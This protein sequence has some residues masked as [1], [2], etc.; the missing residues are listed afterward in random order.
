MK[1][2]LICLAFFMSLISAVKADVIQHREEIIEKIAQSS[3]KVK[4]DRKLLAELREKMR[5]SEELQGKYR[6]RIKNWSAVSIGLAAT[7]AL[8]S[9][10]KLLR[11]PKMAIIISGMIIGV[12]VIEIYRGATMLSFEKQEFEKLQAN[13][14]RVQGHLDLMTSTYQMLKMK[15]EVSKEELEQVE[16]EIENPDNLLL[17]EE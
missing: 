2:V 3:Y 17:I 5:N 7:V 1:K 9:S 15:F 12:G 14:K 8:L 6:I 13:L 11:P 16:V 4:R 10:E